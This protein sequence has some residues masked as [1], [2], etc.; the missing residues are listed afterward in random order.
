MKQILSILSLLFFVSCGTS[1]DYIQTDF[2][3]TGDGV[4]DEELFPIIEKFESM[5]KPL[6]PHLSVRVLDDLEGMGPNVDAVCY[7]NKLTGIGQKV[8]IRRSRWDGKSE[9][10]K[11]QLL[12]HELG[13]CVLNKLDE[14]APLNG[15]CPTSIM[16]SHTF[17]DIIDRYWNGDLIDPRHTDIEQ[18]YKPRKTYY[19]NELSN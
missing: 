11:E 13:H 18:C 1:L 10:G 2:I 7:S 9:E 3:E 12:F 4:I 19:Y 17:S 6:M 14:T 8:E 16:N 5:Y 15:E